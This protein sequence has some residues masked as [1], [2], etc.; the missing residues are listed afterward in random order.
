MVSHSGVW[1]GMV[2]YGMVWY[3]KKGKEICIDYYISSKIISITKS[4]LP[5]L[6]SSLS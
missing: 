3:G 1:Y 4:M 2:W 5:R 6:N